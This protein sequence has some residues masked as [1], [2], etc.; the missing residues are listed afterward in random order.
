MRNSRLQFEVSAVTNSPTTS[1]VIH[2]AQFISKYLYSE[3]AL[4]KY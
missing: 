4:R 2:L 1:R 3:P